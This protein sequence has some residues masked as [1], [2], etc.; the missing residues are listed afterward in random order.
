MKYWSVADYGNVQ[1]VSQY[2]APSLLAHNAHM[3]GDTAVISHYESGVAIVDFSDP[4]NPVQLALYDTWA[5]SEQPGFNGNWGVFPHTGSGRVYASN[6]SNQLII[7]EPDILVTNDT[8][9]GDTVFAQADQTVRVDISL[10]NEHPIRVINIPFEW[11]GPL[12]LDIDSI[13]T[14]GLRTEYFDGQTFIAFDNLNKRAAY[15]LTA[16]N[17]APLPPGSGPVFSIYFTVPPG[18]PDDIN[19]IVLDGFTTLVPEVA[20]ACLQYTAETIAGAVQVGGVDNCCLTTTGNINADPNGD[21]TLTDLTLL[22]NNL[23]VT[24]EALP[25]PRA[26]NTSGDVACDISLTDLTALVNHLFVTFAPL[27]D[28]D[29]SCN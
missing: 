23:F 29:P 3:I 5:I 4:V 28:C 13:G 16:N 18:A 26:A 7:L 27:A 2:L 20:T 15:S 1:L 6:M 22:V 17:V 14:D 10:S 19:P 25:C 11:A 21:V 24:F 9:V 8:L 12:D